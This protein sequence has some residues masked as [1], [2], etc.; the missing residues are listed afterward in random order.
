VWVNA[1]S[2]ERLVVA[3][4]A[5]ALAVTSVAAQAPRRSATNAEALLAAAG[6]FHGRSVV[7]Q[8]RFQQER[9]L[10][11][12]IDSSK[13]IYVFW[14]QRPSSDQGEVRGEFWDLGR[15]EQRDSRLAGYDLSS[16]LESVTRGQWPG[17]DQVYVILNA[18]YMPSVPPK[19]PTIRSIV[20]A[21]DDYVD[22]EVR[23]IGRFK[24]RN[25]YGEVPLAIGKSKW[26]FVIESADGS[27]WVTGLRPRGKGFDL[28]PGKRVDTGRWLEV[29]GVV[30]RDGSTTYIE[31]TFVGEASPAEET[32]VEVELPARPPEPPP[33]VIFSAPI[34]DDVDVERGAKIRV[35]FSRDINPKT[36]RDKVR[37]SYLDDAG[38]EVTD[39]RPPAHSVGY[40]DEAHALEI[41]FAEP[42]SAARRDLGARWTAAAALVADLHDGTVATVRRRH[43]RL[44]ARNNT[45]AKITIRMTHT[46]TTIAAASGYF[47][48]RT[49]SETTNASSPRL[50]SQFENGSGLVLA[51]ARV[52]ALLK[53]DPAARVPP[54]SPT[55]ASVVGLASPRVV[56]AM[57]TP[58]IGRM[59]V[60][61]ASH[62]E[63]NQGILS[64]TNSTT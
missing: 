59:A 14:K 49:P 55:S 46:I 34:A 28:D 40:N 39:R 44:I 3:L 15:M 47:S 12:L 18:T 4:L 10:T 29:R 8:Q 27:I 48:A 62:I 19:G 51:R 57:T 5:L 36:I 32:A 35:Q 11:R 17:R 30:K 56:T 45:A 21:P 2:A 38:A 9:D 13:P 23:V 60:C 37:V 22:R 50:R 31:G 7:L 6:F 16:L 58:P 53:C 52:P 20:L 33:Q 61:T 42:R 54:S 63:S 1:N 64:A 41:T 43:Q 26:D 25:L 24:G